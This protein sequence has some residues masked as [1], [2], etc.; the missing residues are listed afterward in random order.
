MSTCGLFRAWHL[1]EDLGLNVAL[2]VLPMH[3]PRKRGLPRVRAS[4]VR[5][6]ST[7]CTPPLRSV[8]DVRRLLSWIRSQEPESPIGL[9]SMSLG[10]YIASLVASL[11]DGLSSR[12][13]ASR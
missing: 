8:W 1:H 11:E 4:R 6:R 3:G 7:T 13:S 9:N 2:P 10:A 12:S 5:I